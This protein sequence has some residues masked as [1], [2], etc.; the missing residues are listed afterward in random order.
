MPTITFKPLGRRAGYVAYA[1]GERVGVIHATW[2]KVYG[3][4]CWSVTVDGKDVYFSTRREAARYLTAAARP[5]TP[6]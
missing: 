5:T 3:G 2:R 1:D 4:D 6:R